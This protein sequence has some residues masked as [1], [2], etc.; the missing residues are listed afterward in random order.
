[1]ATPTL[2][3]GAAYLHAKARL[4][5]DI[6]LYRGLV[7]ADVNIAIQAKLD[8]LNLFY[9]LESYA[10]SRAS[11]NRPFL[12]YQDHQWTYREVYDIVLKYG[13]WFKMRFGVAKGEVVAMDFTNGPWFV[14]VWLGIWSIGARPAFINYN[15]TGDQLLHS[16]KVSGARLLVVDEEVRPRITQKVRDTLSAREASD[17]GS[18]IETVFFTSEVEADVMNTHGTREPNA[19]R[20]GLLPQDMAILIFTSGTT[21]LPKPAVVSWSKCLRSGWFVPSWL[22]MKRS[23]RYYT[24]MPLYHSSASLLAFCSTLMN[25]STLV[26]GKKFSTQTFWEEVRQSNATIIQYVGETCRYLIAAP[27]KVDPVTN[28]N[29]DKKHHVRI[30]FGNGLRPDIW[31]R[32]KTRFGIETIAEFYGATEAPSATWNLSSNTFASGAIGLNGALTSWAL[33]K[34]IAI[35]EVDW[36]TESPLRDPSNQNFCK[37]MKRGETGELLYLINAANPTRTFQG[38]YGNRKATEAKIIRDVLKKGDAYFRTGDIV[39]WDSEGRW[40]FK[41]RIGDTFRW[42]SENVSTAEVGEALG[43]HPRILE[44]NVY[45]VEIPH[46]DG[47][48]GCAALQLDTADPSG[49]DGGLMEDVAQHVKGKLPKY[50]V[51]VFLRVVREMERTGTNKQTKAVLRNEGVNPAR[52]REGESMWWL[53]GGTYK[54]FREKEWAELKAGA[55]RL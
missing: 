31:E 53:K 22:G 47:R 43:T 19:T 12:L 32:F 11:A 40:W 26:L 50:A 17:D 3:A 7:G 38:Y 16:V 44:A 35:V 36:A 9:V 45:G 2:L 4:D 23:D 48:A 39:C 42:R 29:L 10:F 15:L 24:C 13:T 33:G 8:R 49:P 5:Y 37:P 27:P 34:Q 41:D 55:V 1:M 21:G 51:P 20:N 54:P 52:L 46:H 28:E 25:G 6:K 14:F 18:P 30:A